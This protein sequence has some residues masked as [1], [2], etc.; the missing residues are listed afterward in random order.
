MKKYSIIITHYNQMPYIFE[1]ID[2]VL[3]QD[4]PNIEL[5]IT[6]DCSK[7]FDKRKIENYI[8]KNRRDNIVNYDFMINEKN[9]GTTKTL[10]KAVSMATGDYIHFFAA[11]DALY[12][13][14][15]VSRF[16]KAF[17]KNKEL[18]MT[19]QCI[20]CG[21]ELTDIREKYVP[22]DKAK[23]LNKESVEKQ[24]VEVARC[25]IY[26]SGATAYDR[27]IFTELG[28]FDEKYKLV[29]DWSFYLLATMKGY[30]IRYLDFV[31]FLHRTGGVSHYEN[32]DLPPHVKAYQK[33]I[34][35]IF[36]DLVIPNL[37]NMEKD[38]AEE[39]NQ[40]YIN[41]IFYYGEKDPE[42]L[43]TRKKIIDKY[44]RKQA[45]IEKQQ[46][47]EE[48]RK[49]AEMQK[50]DKS[51]K[52]DKNISGPNENIVKLFY[53]KLRGFT[54]TQLFHT[55]VYIMIFTAIMD[56]LICLFFEL[57]YKYIFIHIIAYVL[58]LIC[59]KM[60]KIIKRRFL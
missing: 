41:H 57:D 26:G 17:S 30:K 22:A 44:K 23:A 27:R 31:A 40:R 25:C 21:T 36:E 38:I 19:A 58:G 45:R 6:D 47:L 14:T 11:D 20:M 37:E 46:K 5:I 4:Y 7:V 28:L 48:M 55:L 18:I 1:A 35:N 42:L 60:L 32:K 43:E 24:Y 34:L 49:F 50:M 39:I 9:L 59:I 10:N 12:D 33:D 13:S 51:L 8:K 15:V 29:E 3:K 52:I 2:S 56:L 54:H 16:V 53:R